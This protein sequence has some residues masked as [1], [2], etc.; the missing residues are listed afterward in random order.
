MVSYKM[1]AGALF[2]EAGDR[3]LACLDRAC[4]GTEKQIL[5][6]E[7]EVL[8]RTRIGAL[9]PSPD[10]ME[11]TPGR[12]YLMLGPAGALY[13]RALPEY[14]AG[15]ASIDDGWPLSRVPRVDHARLEY[16]GETFLLAMRNSQ[17]YTL[18]DSA[19]HILVQII[20]MG[21]PGGWSVETQRQFPPQFLCGLFVF[22]R[23]L[24]LENQFPV[25]GA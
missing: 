25:V 19:R 1:K 14:A 10:Q 22:C 3:P 9:A 8:L 23:Y 20:H 2:E 5:S 4:F 12:E 21:L 16:G 6:P 24:E 15:D 13:A 17:N 7:G 11:S 18:Y